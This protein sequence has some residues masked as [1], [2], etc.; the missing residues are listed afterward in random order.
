MRFVECPLLIALL[1][2]IVPLIATPYHHQRHNQ[3]PHHYQEI[4]SISDN[5][6]SAML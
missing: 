1:Y 2:L 6:F 3:Q 5:I 4:Y